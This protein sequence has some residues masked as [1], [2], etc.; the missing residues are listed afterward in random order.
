[1]IPRVPRVGPTYAVTMG[2]ALL[3]AFGPGLGL[4]LT[5]VVVYGFGVPLVLPWPALAQIHGLT[6]LFGFVPL[7][8]LATAT[9]LLPRFFAVPL[10]RPGLI[11]LAAGLIA[12]SSLARWAQPFAPFPGREALLVWSGVALVGGIGLA[13]WRIVDLRRR[14]IQP[15]SG[16]TAAW[17]RFLIV[18][19]GSLAAAALLNAVAIVDLVD[20]AAIV[21]TA[22]AEAIAHLLLMGFALGLILAIAS[23]VLHRMLLVR[24]HPG[25]AGAV[26]HLA[27]LYGVSVAGVAL[28][29]LFDSVIARIVGLLVQTSVLAVWLYLIGLYGPAARESN[30]PE[31]TGPTRR[32]F[33]FAFGLLLLGALITLWGHVRAA[34]G[35]A[36]PEAAVL[37][38][39]RH[40]AAQGFLLIVMVVMG[41]RLLPHFATTVARHRWLLESA[42]ALLALGALLRTIP[43]SIA[44][45]QGISGPLIAL[46]GGFSYLGFSVAA[47]P[48]AWSL[49]AARRT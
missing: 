31:V 1:M 3:L 49:I 2:L 7:F 23:R 10:E 4:G 32:W 44:G 9:Q 36:L 17:E 34:F 12:S 16:A 22:R 25:L 38:A 18:G 33:R 13:V 8:V 42:V 24:A 21:P 39:G 29:W 45:Y 11:A 47:L 46:G 5:M 15:T 19:A 28:G 41:G 30:T 26:P 27:A 40:A 35:D 14:S 20:G 6:Q 43:E 37:S 48:L